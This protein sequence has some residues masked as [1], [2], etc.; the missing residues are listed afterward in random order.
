MAGYPVTFFPNKF[1]NTKWEKSAKSANWP[2]F[3]KKR[4][5]IC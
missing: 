3:S 1:K 5:E 4:E 2:P